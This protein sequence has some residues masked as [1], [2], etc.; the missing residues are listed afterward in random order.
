M[1]LSKQKYLEVKRELQ[2][3]VTDHGHTYRIR[4]GKLHF[5]DGPNWGI[6]GGFYEY[7]RKIK[8]KSTG[9][10]GRAQILFVLAHEVRHMLHV[11]QNLYKSYYGLNHHLMHL[12]I[13]GQKVQWRW[14]NCGVAIRAERDCD[15]WALE[16]LAARGIVPHQKTQYRFESTSAY[17]MRQHMKTYLAQVKRI[18]DAR[19]EAYRVVE[20]L[21]TAIFADIVGAGSPESG[22]HP[23]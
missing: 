12:A 23:L 21:E 3:I 16:F 20:A 22:V 2:K 1:R 5:H 7:E 11:K 15:R 18:E 6:E 4:R 8:V 19:Q 9:K 13:K 17:K 10:N 14:P